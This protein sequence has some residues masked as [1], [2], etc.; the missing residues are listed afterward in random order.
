[1]EVGHVEQFRL[2][3]LDPLRAGETLAL[4]AVAI[5]TRVVGDT[6]MAAIAAPLDVTAERRCGNAR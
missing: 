5:T 6:V 2:P 3:V 1:M 4:G